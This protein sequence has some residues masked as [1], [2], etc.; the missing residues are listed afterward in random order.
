MRPLPRT[1]VQ[2]LLLWRLRARH[3]K[4]IQ[5][6]AKSCLHSLS[7]HWEVQYLTNQGNFRAR[8]SRKLPG[9]YWLH[10]ETSQATTGNWIH[11]GYTNDRRFQGS[12][13][14]PNG[15]TQRVSVILSTKL[16]PLFFFSTL[17]VHL[18]NKKTITNCENAAGRHLLVCYR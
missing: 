8:V 14:A 4:D 5:K 18:R 12:N 3:T 10:K 7:F 16:R 9:Y 6:N 17:G 1:A 15:E 11:P 2:S 13:M